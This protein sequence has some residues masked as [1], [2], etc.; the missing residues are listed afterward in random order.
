MGF[1]YHLKTGDSVRSPRSDGQTT[2][3]P[4]ARPDGAIVLL[5]SR[6]HLTWAISLRIRK[7]TM[8]PSLAAQYTLPRTAPLHPVATCVNTFSG[9]A[10]SC[11]LL[12]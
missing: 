11:V 10:G 3:P 7:D 6:R 9:A 8:T 2:S 12:L 1:L 5:A 4:E